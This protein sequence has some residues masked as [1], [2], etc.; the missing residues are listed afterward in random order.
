MEV[1]FSCLEQPL[2][3]FIFYFQQHPRV[4][5]SVLFF[6]SFFF[7][8]SVHFSIY[9]ISFLFICKSATE[10]HHFLHVII[11]RVIRLATRS[12]VGAFDTCPTAS[13]GITLC[14]NQVISALFLGLRMVDPFL[15]GIMRP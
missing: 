8:Y 12:D 10:R 14:L 7:I 2:T 9:F 5:L 6:L 11:S 3:C 13:H 1:R 15:L 4:S